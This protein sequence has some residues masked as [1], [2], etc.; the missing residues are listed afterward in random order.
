MSPN[1]RE[2]R[3]KMLAEILGGMGDN[4]IFTPPSWC[5][6]GYNISVGDYFYANNNLIITDGAK[7][8]LE[9]MFLLL[10]TVVLQLP[11]MPSTRNNV[12]QGWKLQSRLPSVIM[13]GLEQEVWFQN[14]YQ[15]M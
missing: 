12:R 8:S 15:A 14:P 9:T 7:V 2:T 3:Q 4:V 6:Y 13:F 1:D 11:N 5:D 10:R